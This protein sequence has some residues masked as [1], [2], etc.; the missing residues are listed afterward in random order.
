VVFGPSC[1]PFEKLTELKSVLSSMLGRMATA[2]PIGQVP[3][4]TRGVAG[5]D[6]FQF[7]MIGGKTLFDER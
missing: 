1:V 3:L 5:P 2:Q 6:R 4:P 7:P